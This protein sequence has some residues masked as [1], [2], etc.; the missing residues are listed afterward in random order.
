[1]FGFRSFLC[2]KAAGHILSPFIH[3]G[4]MDQAGYH[5]ASGGRVCPNPN[6]HVHRLSVTL[7]EHV[8]VE[9]LCPVLTICKMIMCFALRLRSVANHIMYTNKFNLRLPWQDFSQPLPRSCPHPTTTPPIHNFIW[10][11]QDKTAFPETKPYSLIAVLESERIKSHPFIQGKPYMQ[12]LLHDF[13][14][15]TPKALPTLNSHLCRSFP[16]TSVCISWLC[17]R[18]E[19]SP[20]TWVSKDLLWHVTGDKQCWPHWIN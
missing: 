9:V 11:P 10:S 5:S 15:E 2:L 4:R 20:R 6:S 14:G 13:P 16:N 12:F 7:Q 3:L 19:N 18:Q 1:M 17:Q 8:C